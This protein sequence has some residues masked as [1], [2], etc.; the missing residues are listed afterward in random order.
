MTDN[1][2]K[3]W[4]NAE[5]DFEDELHKHFEGTE[6][7][8]WI[9]SAREGSRVYSLMFDVEIEGGSPIDGLFAAVAA[10]ASETVFRAVASAFG[11]TIEEVQQ[12]LEDWYMTGLPKSRPPIH[13]S[14]FVAECRRESASD[15]AMSFRD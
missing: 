1:E 11:L 8:D 3:N 4:Q 2:I 14:Q 7:S 13:P 5:T 9:E 10:D 12:G 15:F 6:R